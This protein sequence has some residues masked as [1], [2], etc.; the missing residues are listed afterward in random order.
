MSTVTALSAGACAVTRAGEA[1]QGRSRLGYESKNK[2]MRMYFLL[3]QCVTQLPYKAILAQ[4]TLA[5]DAGEGERGEAST[6]LEV[7]WC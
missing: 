6:T 2:L 1:V 7:E 5:W 4:G 3:S